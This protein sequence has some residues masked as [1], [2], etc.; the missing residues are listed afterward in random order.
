MS[1]QKKRRSGMWV[2]GIPPR[3]LLHEEPTSEIGESGE[4]VEVALKRQRDEARAHAARLQRRIDQD[5]D[6]ASL[7][8]QAAHERELLEQT[9]D[10]LRKAM[11]ALARAKEKRRQAHVFDEELKA[12]NARLTEERDALRA[13]RDRWKDRANTGLV[14]TQVH[15]TP[16]AQE[17]I[18]RL[19]EA[20]RTLQELVRLRPDIAEDGSPTVPDGV[21]VAMESI[22]GDALSQDID[23]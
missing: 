13:E 16:A 19:E 3:D 20:L 15:P 12:Q 14:V 4:S 21:R 9:Q 6:R 7:A 22:I 11:D 18:A 8:G 10:K 17:R 23:R 5:T 1:D 2:G